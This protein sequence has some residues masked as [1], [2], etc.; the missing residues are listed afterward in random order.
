[1]SKENPKQESIH[2]RVYFSDGV[3]KNTRKAKNKDVTKRKIAAI[4][5]HLERQPG[6]SYAQRHLSKLQGAL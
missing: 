1:M 3:K 4:E 5:G 2:P 6:D